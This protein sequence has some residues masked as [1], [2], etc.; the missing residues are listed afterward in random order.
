MSL[1]RCIANNSFHRF[2]MSHDF[3]F[4][5]AWF[6][7]P[8]DQFL[9]L[10]PPSRLAWNLKTFQY[11]SGGTPDPATILVG[12]KLVG[13]R[14]VPSNNNSRIP[15]NDSRD[16]WDLRLSWQY[17]GYMTHWK[18]DYIL[19]FAAWWPL[20]RMGR[21]MFSNRFDLNCRAILKVHKARRT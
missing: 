18:R 2:L 4:V 12:G 5:L 10:L 17:R 7:L 9:W 15:E 13:S 19:S 16:S 14:P 21:L 6:W 3:R 8:W 11:D 20:T 1:I